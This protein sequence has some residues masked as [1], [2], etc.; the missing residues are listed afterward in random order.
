M[1]DLDLVRFSKFE[2]GASSRTGGLCREESGSHF[3]GPVIVEVAPRVFSVSCQDRR[4]CPQPIAPSAYECSR[5]RLG[6]LATLS[7][8]RPT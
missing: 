2:T 5:R 3:L 1:F 4:D 8:E 6:P 7:H